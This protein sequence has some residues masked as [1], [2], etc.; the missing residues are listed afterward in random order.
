MADSTIE[1]IRGGK[2]A[3]VRAA[4]KANPEA[5]RHPKQAASRGNARTMQAVLDTGG[6]LGC[7][8][9]QGRTSINVVTLTGR[10]KLLA[11]MP[12][13]AH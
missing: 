8:D 13:A 6:D 5:A 7:R 10:N 1:A 4:V 3:A 12:A 11:L 9:K 2:L